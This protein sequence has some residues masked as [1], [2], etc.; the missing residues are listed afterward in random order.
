ME[1]LTASWSGS[2]NQARCSWPKGYDKPAN[3]EYLPENE[4]MKLLKTDLKTDSDHL[5]QHYLLMIYFVLS[6]V[7]YR[8]QFDINTNDDILREARLKCEQ[9]I[10]ELIANLK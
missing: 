4:K 1:F 6:I 3:L 9:V 2:I 7:K 10:Q 5:E 8:S